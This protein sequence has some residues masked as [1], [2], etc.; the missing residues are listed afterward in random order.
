ML[1]AAL[2][3][4]MIA[5]AGIAAVL[6]LSG[7]DEPTSRPGPP[8]ATD[9]R[10]ALLALVPERIRDSCTQAMP[11]YGAVVQL[12]CGPVNTVWQVTYARHEDVRGLEHAFEEER[13]LVDADPGRR[14]PPCPDGDT[15]TLCYRHTGAN[16]PGGRWVVAAADADARVLTTV[17]QNV[18]GLRRG[19]R[20]WLGVRPSR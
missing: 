15:E 16:V 5:A 17:L 1:R 10:E 14:R 13:Q 3:A 19:Y 4:A 18:G 7:Q 20:T 9:P 2:I 8:R 12:G 11:E 6:A